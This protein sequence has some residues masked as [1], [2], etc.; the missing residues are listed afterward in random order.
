MAYDQASAVGSLSRQPGSQPLLTPQELS[1]CKRIQSCTLG[2][3]HAMMAD[4]PGWC[5]AAVLGLNLNFNDP[6]WMTAEDVIQQCT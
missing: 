5:S 2:S 6:A 3:I 4:W 1:N